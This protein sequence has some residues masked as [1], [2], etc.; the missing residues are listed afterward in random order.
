MSLHPEPWWGLLT[1][2]V[3]VLIG[4][5][6]LLAYIRDPER[7]SRRPTRGEIMPSFLGAL[8]MATLILVAL[9]LAMLLI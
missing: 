1:K 8:A 9:S 3:V 4:V 2:A 5:D 6:L 7:F